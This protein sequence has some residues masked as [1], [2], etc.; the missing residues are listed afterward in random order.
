MTG[1]IKRIIMGLDRIKKTPC[2]FC[3]VEYYTRRD[4]LDAQKFVNGTKLDERVVRTDVDPGFQAGRQYGRGRSGGQ[5]RDEHREDY[6]EGR[7]GWGARIREQEL[8][9]QN[10]R[11][12]YDGSL[13]VPEGS[14][15]YYSSYSQNKRDREDDEDYGRRSRFRDGSRS[16]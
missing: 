4:A 12:V 9:E 3:F 7:G 6:D 14:H 16:P 11:D 10:T 1:E 15:T 5:V 8:R 2:G 13:S